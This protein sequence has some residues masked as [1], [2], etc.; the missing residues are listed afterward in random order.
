MELKSDET[1]I[2]FQYKNHNIILASD[3]GVFSKDK[4]DYGTRV[5]LDAIDI[6]ENIL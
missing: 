6:K 2:Y 4:V 3:Y 5:L 1:R